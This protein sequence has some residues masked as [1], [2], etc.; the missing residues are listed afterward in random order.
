MHGCSL[1]FWLRAAFLGQLV[2]TSLHRYKGVGGNKA[3]SFSDSHDTCDVGGTFLLRIHVSIARAPR[4]WNESTRRLQAQEG[5]R[6]TR[7]C[8]NGDEK[9][10]ELWETKFWTTYG[11]RGRPG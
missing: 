8:F 10:Y 11:W 7:L 6:W 2:M 4:S 3:L 9:N 5:P 1:I